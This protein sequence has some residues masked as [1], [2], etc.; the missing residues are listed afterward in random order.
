MISY[1]LIINIRLRAVV[2]AQDVLKREKQ[3]VKRS[4][5]FIVK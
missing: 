4:L 3:P 1:F 5:Y 2:A